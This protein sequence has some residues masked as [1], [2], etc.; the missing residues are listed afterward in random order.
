MYGIGAYGLANRLEISQS[1]AKEIIARYFNRFQKFNNILVIRLP[2]RAKKD[3]SAR[4]LA[5]GGI[6]ADI[7]STIIISARMQNGKP[8]ICPSRELRR[9]WLNLLWFHIDGEI[10]SETSSSMLLQVH[11]EL[12]L[13]CRMNEEADLKN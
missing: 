3:M 11:D 12:V 10:L 7:R 5:D 4:S 9:I 13:K 6:L 2:G 1:E 8:S